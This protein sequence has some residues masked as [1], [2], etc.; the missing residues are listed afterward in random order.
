MRNIKGF[1]KFEAIGFK[2]PNDNRDRETKS[3]VYKEVGYKPTENKER[4]IGYY[5]VLLK[6]DSKWTIGLYDDYNEWEIIACDEILTDDSFD[7]IGDFI[8]KPR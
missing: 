1:E 7:K 4:E 2:T 6:G 3:D 5:W 8:S